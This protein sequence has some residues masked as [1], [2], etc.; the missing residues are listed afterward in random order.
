M[1]AHAV[2]RM[3]ALMAALAGVLLAGPA[4][5]HSDLRSSDPDD[6]ATLTTAPAA[7]SFTFNEPLLAE[8]NA[9]TVTEVATG[10]RLAVGATEVDVQTATASWPES[11]PA[12]EFRAAYRV[13]S[14]DGH[15]IDGTI[16]FT[17]AQAAGSGAAAGRSQPRHRARSRGADGSPGPSGSTDATD[18][19]SPVPA[20]EPDDDGGSSLL[21][22]LV[23]L[24][25]AIALGAG[26]GTWFMRRTR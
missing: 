5:A 17:V 11:S 22:L 4:Q 20:D 21:A 13:V 23:A 9:I 24:G 6:G 18:T 25:L 1:S 3:V 8:G 16:T 15:P 10:Q 7:V 19:A 12:G 14:A 26:A 2:R